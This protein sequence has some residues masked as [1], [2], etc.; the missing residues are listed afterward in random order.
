MNGRAVLGVPGEAREPR[1]MRTVVPNGRAW[2]RSF[3]RLGTVVL[4]WRGQRKAAS[5]VR[6]WPMTS[7][8][9]S[10]VPS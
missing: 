7:W 3:H 4:N 2:G 6:A 1:Q 5:P 9:T 8:W 10:D